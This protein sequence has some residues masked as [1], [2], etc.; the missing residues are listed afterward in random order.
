MT[1]RGLSRLFPPT[2]VEVDGAQIDVPQIPILQF[3]VR[4]RPGVNKNTAV[5]SLLHDFGR[6]V[7]A[8]YP[9]GEVGNLAKV[10]SLPYVLAAVLVVLAVGALA[11]TLLSSVRRHRRDLAVLKTIGFI[12]PQVSATVAWQATTL[13]IGALIVGVPGGV[14]L[15]RWTWRLVANNAGSVSPA[16]V[17][18]AAVLVVIPATLV[19]ANLLAGG[20]AWAAGRVQPARVLKAE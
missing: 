10:D 9:G 1:V 3:A 14:A 7:L 11:L 20:P 17:P 12:R 2:R 5:Q 16:V 6:E 4:F 8:P 19:V 15:G 13:A 18:L